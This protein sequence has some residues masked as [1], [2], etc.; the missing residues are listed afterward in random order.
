M[1]IFIADGDI[2]SPD[3]IPIVASTPEEAG[4]LAQTFANILRDMGFDDLEGNV[5]QS[6]GG[7]EYALSWKDAEAL[8]G[9]VPSVMY[10]RENNGKARFPVNGHLPA[11]RAW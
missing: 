5:L 4:I 6:D 10:R 1:Q 11:E 9:F 8:E 2:L 3:L 7:F